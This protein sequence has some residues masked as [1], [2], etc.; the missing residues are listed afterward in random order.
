MCD[1]LAEIECFEAK[2]NSPL[3]SFL[4][5]HHRHKEIVREYKK[6]YPISKI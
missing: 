1:V 3:N 2:A 6:Y 4:S 5:R